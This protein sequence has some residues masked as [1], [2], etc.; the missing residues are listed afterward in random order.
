MQTA[1]QHAMRLLEL[2]MAGFETNWKFF[3]AEFNQFSER[4]EYCHRLN[5]DRDDNGHIRLRVRDQQGADNGYL[6]I[7]LTVA[8]ENTTGRMQLKIDL[9]PVQPDA[10]EQGDRAGY[11]P[12]LDYFSLQADG[13]AALNRRCF[14]EI[15]AS[16]PSMHGRAFGVH[17]QN[18]IGAQQAQAGKIDKKDLN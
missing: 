8:P 4:G 10:V 15:M 16:L 11:T 9:F 12:T 5:I 14:A 13:Q 1:Y 17:Y 6:S 2:S 18:L 7:E 3:A